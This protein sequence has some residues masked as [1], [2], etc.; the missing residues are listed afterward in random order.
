[1]VRAGQLREVATLQRSKAAADHF[2]ELSGW[3]DVQQVMIGIEPISSGERLLADQVDSQTT[4]RIQMHFSLTYV[5]SS[6]MRIKTKRPGVQDYDPAKDEHHRIFNIESVINVDEAN[7]A[8]ELM[9]SEQ[10]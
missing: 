7:R 4:H 2:V 5:V 8:L 6:G 9:C 1:M 3:E 10:T